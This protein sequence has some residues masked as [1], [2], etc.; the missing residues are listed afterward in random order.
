MGLLLVLR[1]LAPGLPALLALE[2]W[3]L[4]GHRSSRPG[5]DAGAI[6]TLLARVEPAGRPWLG[7]SAAGLAAGLVGGAEGPDPVSLAL[8]AGSP[9]EAV[10][11]G[12]EAA[13]R[14]PGPF[15]MVLAAGA[16]AW[17]VTGDPPAARLLPPGAT[18]VAA[19]GCREGLPPPADLVVPGLGRAAGLGA[20]AAWFGG[21]G[22]RGLLPPA[23]GEPLATAI[24]GPGPGRPREGV[25]LFAPGGA[26]RRE[27]LDYGSL[28]PRLETGP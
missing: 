22:L 18:L 25:L 28:L 21:P 1:D 13:R 12:L 7:L 16:Q 2:R 15:A 6:P 26:G 5:L 11:A 9:A 4:P 24:F 8:A 20:V 10:A 27:L 23:G 19:G 3:G 17:L 14:R